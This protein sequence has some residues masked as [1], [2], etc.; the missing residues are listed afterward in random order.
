[1]RK[2]NYVFF[3]FAL[4]FWINANVWSGR[5]SETKPKRKAKKK[6]NRMNTQYHIIII[7]HK[8]VNEKGWMTRARSR[9][10]RRRLR[11][12]SSE[13]QVS[14]HSTI[15]NNMWSRCV[16]RP[17]YSNVPL[18]SRYARVWYDSDSSIHSHNLSRIP[19]T[20][21]HSKHTNR[22]WEVFL[23]YIR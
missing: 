14:R 23:F 22:N 13:S 1:M 6:K 4:N 12:I 8:W 11:I 20:Q 3:L 10:L 16:C 7:S 15:I 2:T 18:C 19:P 9:S 5:L 21:T 17:G